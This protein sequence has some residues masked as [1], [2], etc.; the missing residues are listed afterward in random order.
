MISAMRYPLVCLVLIPVMTGSPP[1]YAQTS[2]PQAG[3]SLR[4]EARTFLSPSQ[5]AQVGYYLYTPA[6]YGRDTTARFPLLLFL[7]GIGERGNGTTELVRVLKFGPPR[8][9]ERGRD[10]PFLVVTPQLPAS[11]E[12][13]PVELIDDV[14][15]ELQRTLRVDSSRIYLTGLSDGGDASWNYAMA[16]PDIPA[17]IVP[18]ASEA[19]PRGI[20]AMREVPVWAFHGELDRDVKL[21]V[22]QRLV[23]ALNACVPPPK[24]PARL[25]VYA[26]AGHLVWSRTYD[27]AEGLDIYGWLLQ[28]HR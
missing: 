5:G 12:H 20:C 10:Y 21:S 7:H 23:Q 13:W 19:S 27:G 17:A 15:A 25:T 14:I 28:H 6:D 1:A 26:G 24:E 18:I 11:A 9:I 2:Q 4:Q 16:R 3:Q 8:L 22:E